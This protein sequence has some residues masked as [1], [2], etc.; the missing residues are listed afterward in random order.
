MRRQVRPP[1]S[2]RQVT[3]GVW[4]SA[5]IVLGIAFLLG[6]LLG[7][8]MAAQVEGDGDDSLAFYIETYLEAAREGYAGPASLPALLWPELRYFLLVFFLSFTAFGV[9]GIPVVFGVRAFFLSFAAASFVRMFSGFGLLLALAVF[10]VAAVI[11]IPALFVLG[12]QGWNRS[13]ALV[14]QQSGGRRKLHAP[15]EAFWIRCGVC[16]G[17]VFL[18]VLAEQT[19]GFQL[20]CLLAGRM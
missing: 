3:G 2:G 19:L 5:L 10:G 11:S 1:K 18:C 20:L 7:C 14:P 9:L 12:A 13:M 17:C 16:F 6:M 8:L 15:E 4:F